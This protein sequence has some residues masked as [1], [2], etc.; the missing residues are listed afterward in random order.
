MSVLPN[1]QP[2]MSMGPAI[3][4]LD[5]I[6]SE[7]QELVKECKQV[8]V[9]LPAAPDGDMNNQRSTRIVTEIVGVA[10]PI[11]V[12]VKIARRNKGEC[13]EIDELTGIVS[14]FLPQFKNTD[15]IKDPALS[16]ELEKIVNTFKHAYGLLFQTLIAVLRSS[17]RRSRAF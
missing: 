9:P 10:D 16:A 1:N 14:A 3:E 2:L 13:L 7:A 11:K 15:M 12:K 17:L 4:A 6:P 5:K 8:H